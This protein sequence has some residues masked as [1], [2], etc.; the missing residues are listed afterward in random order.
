M[1]GPGVV[2][3]SDALARAVDGLTHGYALRADDF[4]SEIFALLRCPMDREILDAKRELGCFREALLTAIDAG[5]SPSQ[6]E[7][8]IGK[9]KTDAGRIGR[10][11]KR[12]YRN[13]G[14]PETYWRF[15]FS[16]HL[17]ARRGLVRGAG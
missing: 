16:K 13:D 10:A 3:L 8:C 11:R 7:E 2:K 15:Q 12:Y 9:A 4:A 14:S 17:D 5:L 6:I 1:G